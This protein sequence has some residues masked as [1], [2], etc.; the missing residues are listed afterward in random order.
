MKIRFSPLFLTALPILALAAF[1]YRA[2]HQRI[3]ALERQPELFPDGKKGRIGPPGRNRRVVIG[4]VGGYRGLLKDSIDVSRLSH[5]NYAFVDIRND[6]AW[7]HHEAVDTVNLRYLVGLK[8]RNP[9]LKILISIGGWSWSK[10][11]SDAVLTDSTRAVF[12]SSAI[13]IVSRYDL[14]GVDIDWEYPGQIGD[15]NKFRP[16][17]KQDYTL[18]FKKLREG[19]DSLGTVNA[20]H[21][22]TTTAVGADRP[23]IEHTEMGKVQRY[24][25]YVNIM[26]YDFR[27]GGDDLSGH[28]TNLYPSKLDPDTAKPC[29]D[30]AVRLF[31]AAGV[32]SSK[33]VMGIAFYAHSWTVKTTDRHGLYEASD[34]S[35]K[36]P[37]FHQVGRESDYTLIK[38]SIVGRNGFARY[39][40]ADAHAPYI[41]QADQKILLSYDD[42]ESVK[43]KCRYVEKNRLAG[44]MFWEY[45]NDK[46]G[47]LLHAIGE[48]LGYP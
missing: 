11:F 24:L 2:S 3:P 32:P 41:F 29:A 19:L 14:D 15:G 42:E 44:V 5:I 37:L 25:D 16:E 18:F 4:Y 35:A 10:L 17:D 26:S 28:H 40:D 47:Y 45:S 30:K 9:D 48:E 1:S 13:D 46:K 33:L 21:Y 8:A 31:E 12:A 6:R 23:F 34:R 22:F 36:S 38:D 43:D 7:L 20:K 39:W 27:E